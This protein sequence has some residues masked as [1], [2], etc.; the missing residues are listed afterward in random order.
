MI[1][2]NPMISPTALTAA[3]AYMSRTAACTVRADRG[4][5]GRSAHPHAAADQV[6]GLGQAGAALAVPSPGHQHRE[7]LLPVLPPE[8]RRIPGQQPPV[9]SLK[10]RLIGHV[11]IPPARFNRVSAAAA[12]ACSRA[13]SAASRLV[14]A[15]VSR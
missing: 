12:A 14:P 5:L 7:D 10:V 9:P 4:T 3:P 11:A 13:A 8:L 2:A 1:R 15:G 6:R